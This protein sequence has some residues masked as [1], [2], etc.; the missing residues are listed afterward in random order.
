MVEV[1]AWRLDRL[2]GADETIWFDTPLSLRR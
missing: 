1:G 2:P